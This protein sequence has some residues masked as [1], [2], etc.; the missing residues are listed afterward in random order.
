MNIRAF[1]NDWLLRYGTG[2][3]ATWDPTGVKLLADGR[4]RLD[5]G[6]PMKGAGVVLQG[7]SRYGTYV[8]GLSGRLDSIN[9][10]A[11]MAVWLYDDRPERTE[12]MEIDYEYSLWNDQN[13][14]KGVMLSLHGRQIGL[15]PEYQ[16]KLPT[17]AFD[18][19]RI[20]IDWRA[21]KCGVR[22]EGWWASN[23]KWMSYGE[24]QVSRQS[25]LGATLRV[26]LWQDQ[27]VL[28][29]TSNGLRTVYFDS[30]SYSP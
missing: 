27:R 21:D 29:G 19:H 1:N 4:I 23:N 10:G 17:R 13:S 24:F 22:A 5:L 6:G 25:P 8:V 30:F 3:A 26:G 18:K 20:T 12:I 2:G 15:P 28:P 9:P 7:P 14:Y 11:C 16:Q